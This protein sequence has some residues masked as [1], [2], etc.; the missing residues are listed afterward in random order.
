VHYRLYLVVGAVKLFLIVINIFDKHELF[1][2]LFLQLLNDILR[3][4]TAT[5]LSSVREDKARL[6][7]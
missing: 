5:E 1:Q 2:P 6:L 7:S 3:I 4:S